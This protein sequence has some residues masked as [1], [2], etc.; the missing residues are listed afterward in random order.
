[1]A[2]TLTRLQM[3]TEVIAKLGDRTDINTRCETW[4]DFAQTRL[5]R[6]HDFSELRK[7]FTAS[8][9]VN[10]LDYKWPSTLKNVFDLR[11][12]D[13]TNS[14]KLVPRFPR[15]RDASNPNPPSITTGRPRVYIPWGRVFELDPVPNASY[16]L[17]LRC[18]LWPTAFSVD[19][20]VSDF[21]QKDEILIELATAIGYA[22]LMENEDAAAHVALAKEMIGGAID[23][24]M[25][26]K[27]MAFT[28][29]PA[30]VEYSVMGRGTYWADPL[31]G[32]W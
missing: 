29:R 23:K 26:V 9:V 31:E 4:L 20:S 14:R 16:T 3:R 17:R 5:A 19:G 12:I 2:G 22:S 21:D 18:S 11:L 1:M 7:I 32:L 15:E 24:D 27:D 28:P 6:E 25:E 10:Q 8:T 13:G 30:T